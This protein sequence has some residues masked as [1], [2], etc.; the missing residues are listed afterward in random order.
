MLNGNIF[1]SNPYLNGG[2]YSFEIDDQFQCGPVDVSGLFNCE[3][4]TDAGQMTAGVASFCVDTLAQV[5][6]STNFN[7]DPDD[8]LVYVLHTNSDTTLG[9]VIATSDIPEFD[10][11]PATMSTGVTYYISAIAGNDNGSGNVDLNDPCFDVSAGTPVVFNDLPTLAVS[12]ETTICNGETTMVTFTLTGIGP[13][14][15]TYEVD[16]NLQPA[17]P[18]PNPGTFEVPI[19]PSLSTQYS[20]VSIADQ[21]TGCSNSATGTVDIT[22]NEP[23]NAGDPYGDFEVCDNNNFTIS[24]FENVV[25]FEYGGTW[26]DQNG[27][28]YPNGSL[29]T[30]VLTP[31]TTTFTYTILG[32]AP[33]PDDQVSIDVIIHPAPVADAGDDVTLDCDLTSTMIGG[34]NTTPGITYLWEGGTVSDPTI[35]QPNIQEAGEFILTATTP[36]NC[37]DMDTM[38]AFI[39]QGIPSPVVSV[40]DVSCFGMNDGY[41][42]IDDITGGN[43]PYTCSFNGGPFTDD[44]LFQNL[45]PG[46]YNIVIEDDSGCEAI[47]NFNIGQPE[48]VDVEINP[49]LPVEVEGDPYIAEYDV[50]FT[51]EIITNP[52]FGE[53]DTVIWSSTNSNDTT[54]CGD[55]EFNE[56]ALQFQTTF[57][58][59]VVEDGCPDEDQ[60]TI[61][62][63]RDHIVYIPNAFSPNADGTNDFFRIYE[64]PGTIAKV[65]SF[66]VFSRWGETVYEFYDF[67]IDD[68][69]F[70]GWDGKHQGETM[71]PAVFTWFAE[72][73]YTDGVVRHYEGDVSLLR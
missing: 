22:V 16:G 26:T 14:L 64:N 23:V 1:T 3:C 19:A 49:I 2:S 48:Q 40:T 60:L 10:F 44:K 28:E 17:I 29:D 71:N 20:L 24:L 69:E 38:Y 47:L 6:P 11:D 5:S 73:E 41:I 58:V 12:G 8:V 36:F 45:S 33:C 34:N 7:L 55:C 37:V 31:G 72:I 56:L 54:L 15:I 59:Q 25:G 43:P 68:P 61:F 13:F 66:L 52:P 42:Q 35:P 50:P 39:S 70:L 18:V 4:L 30:D 51:I 46:D 9:T 63:E 53:L 65:N 57:S 67:T 21:G 32:T 27:N 62:V